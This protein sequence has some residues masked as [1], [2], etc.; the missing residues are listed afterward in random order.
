MVHDLLPVVIGTA[1][2]DSINPFAI[3]A[4]LLLVAT[5]TQAGVKQRKVVFMGLVYVLAIFATYLALGTGVLEVLFETDITRYFLAAIS[6]VVVFVGVDQLLEFWDVDLIRSQMSPEDPRVQKFIQRT[7]A[8]SSAALGVV[9][10]LLELP[11]TGGPYFAI[12][13]LLAAGTFSVGSFALLVLYNVIVVLPLVGILFAAWLG[14]DVQAANQWREDHE[15]KVGLF[16]GAFMI[17]LGAG[18]FAWSLFWL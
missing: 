15:R 11:A 5:A 8:S 17:L 13:A 9:V 1:V 3:G 2:V 12:T 18:L 16:T 6:V 10:A 14:L 4:L 7:K